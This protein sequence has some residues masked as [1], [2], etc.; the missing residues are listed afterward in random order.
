MPSG[1]VAAGAADLS[2]SA[3]PVGIATGPLWD[4]ILGNQA[5]ACEPR[6]EGPGKTAGLPALAEACPW[7]R[8]QPAGNG[9][10]RKITCP[11]SKRI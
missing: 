4:A 3:L 2:R 8:L 9:R 10:I 11:R 1:A 6:L 5:R 7:V